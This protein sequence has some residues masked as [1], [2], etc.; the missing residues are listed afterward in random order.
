MGTHDRTTWV[1]FDTGN[2]LLVA[3]KV[4]TF[5]QRVTDPFFEASAEPRL[6]LAPKSMSSDQHRAPGVVQRGS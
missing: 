6:A 3:D 5:D 2:Q 1:G 4:G